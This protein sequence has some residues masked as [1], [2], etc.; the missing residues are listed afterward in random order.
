MTINCSV[1]KTKLRFVQW[2]SLLVAAPSTNE[3]LKM[4]NAA[5]DLVIRF[6]PA[7]DKMDAHTTVSFTSLNQLRKV[8]VAA[9]I[10]QTSWADTPSREATAACVQANAQTTDPVTGSGLQPLGKGKAGICDLNDP[11]E[12]AP[13]GFAEKLWIFWGESWVCAAS[14]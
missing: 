11:I 3:G 5:R 2:K 14:A 10:P 1:L 4:K 9:A 12:F 8:Q 6:V 7:L 13:L